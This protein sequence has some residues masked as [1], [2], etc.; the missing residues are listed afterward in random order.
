MDGGICVDSAGVGGSCGSTAVSDGTIIADG[1]I[2]A[3]AF[4]LAERMASDSVYESGSVVVVGRDGV[5]LST[6][7]YDTAVAGVVSTEPGTILGWENKGRTEVLL[8]LA[9]TVPVKASAENGPIRIGDL[10]T[11]SDTPGHAMR[12]ADRAKCYG[13][14]LGKAMEPL[15]KGTGKIKM[16]VMLR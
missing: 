1:S 2:T 3:N 6:S 9:G 12:C 16:L 4:D 8:S 14:L 11:T 10:L 15:E 7:A 13:A 5:T